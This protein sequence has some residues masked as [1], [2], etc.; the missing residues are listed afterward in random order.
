MFF[1]KS[2]H[3]IDDK[4]RLALPAK[5]RKLITGKIFLN[6]DLT[7]EYVEIVMNDTH[8]KRQEFLNSFDEF[9]I[10]AKQIKIFLNAQTHEMKIDSIGRINIPHQIVTQLKINKE[11]VVVG[12]GDRIIVWEANAYNK[13][14]ESQKS[15]LNAEIIKIAKKLSEKKNANK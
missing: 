3:N 11:V 7:G 2:N 1:G 13:K 8:I 9:D 12:N 10:E 4:G 5:F 6:V 15:N 14:F